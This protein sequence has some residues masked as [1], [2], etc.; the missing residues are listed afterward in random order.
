MELGFIGT[1]TITAAMVTG[2]RQDGGKEPS[3]LLSPR[4]QAVASD[5]SQRFP[6]VGVAG[7]NQEVLDACDTVVLAVRPQIAREVLGELRFRPEHHA[8]SVISGFS[9]RTLSGL[10]APAQRITRAVPLPSAAKRRCPTAVYPGDGAAMEL[11]GRL[12]TAFAARTEQEFDALCTATATLASYF[13][14]A[15]G[16]AT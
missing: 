5:L 10:V 16:V 13:G 3:I 1:G 11:F 6:R 9:V 7:S 8:I 4:N 15:G 14:F 12:G 2:L